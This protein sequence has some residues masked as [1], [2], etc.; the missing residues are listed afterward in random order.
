[1]STLPGTGKARVVIVGGGFGG[2]YAAKALGK[3]PVNL[4]VVDRRNFHLFQPLLYQVATGGLSPGE[5]ASPLR[6][7]L[8][9]HKNTRVWLGEVVDI[10]VDHRRLIL[11]DGQLDYDILVL[12]TG[13]THHYFGHDEWAQYAPGL[14]TVEDATEIRRRILLAFEH[15]E[16]EPDPAKRRAWLTFIIVGGGPTGVELAGALG[17]IAND[18]LRHDF[19]SINPA[20][21]QIL[22]LE[23]SSRLLQAF[24]PD[25]SHAA[26]CEL[27]GLGVRPRPGAVVT[28][29]DANGVTVRI[30]EE[31]ER[32]PTHT[33]LWAAGVQASP[34]GKI[35]AERAA[36]PLDRA[37]RVIVEPDLSV[38]GHPEILVIGDLA[39]FSHQT[40]KPLPGVAPVAMAQ[41]RYVARL[42]TARQKG[43]VLPPFHYF[44]KGNLATVGRNEAV[45]DFG[46][47]RLSGFIAWV[48]WLF[49]HLMYLVE[50]DNRLLVLTEWV[51]NYITRNRG[52]R[53]ITGSAD[54]PSTA[55][56]Q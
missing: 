26:E 11:A 4:T 21:A 3:A 13:S 14:K 38:P 25:L 35:L 2:L 37:G 15:A 28:N 45:A 40:G 10:D 27:I 29:V 20:E 46:K 1:M 16:R 34:L 18:T 43:K 32:I 50:F 56:G 53:L 6:V 7:V 8:K 39:N 42:I 49:V 5:I 17:E 36:A 31:T 9:R 54:A 55:D 22:L 24:P 41:G 51:Y 19:R 33:V 44:N 30:G 48:A 12:A 52:A 47:V 23:G